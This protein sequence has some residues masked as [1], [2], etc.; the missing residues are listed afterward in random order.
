MLQYLQLG[1]S[2][3]VVKYLL[4]ASIHCLNRNAALNCLTQSEQILPLEKVSYNLK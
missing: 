2:D 4:A 3:L 1:I